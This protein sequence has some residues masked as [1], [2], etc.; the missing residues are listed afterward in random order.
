MLFDTLLERIL[1]SLFWKKKKK[2][3]SQNNSFL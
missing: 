1:G 3:K 2:K